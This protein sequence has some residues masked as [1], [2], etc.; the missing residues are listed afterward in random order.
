[1][2]I[3]AKRYQLYYRHSAFITARSGTLNCNVRMR[4]FRRMGS[5]HSFQRVLYFERKMTVAERAALGEYRP[6]RIRLFSLLFI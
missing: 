6:F 4:I 1:M 5:F 3:H 2:L